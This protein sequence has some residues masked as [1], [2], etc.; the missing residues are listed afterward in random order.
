[1]S[2]AAAQCWNEPKRTKLGDMRVTTAAVSVSSRCTGNSEPTIASARVVGMPRAAIASEHRNSRI[3]ERS[4]AR[5]SPI[6]EY[7]V[8]PAPFNCSSHGPAS[9]RTSPSRW[10]RPSPSRP[11][12]TPNWWP[13]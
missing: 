3:D 9:P 8:R 7:G 2:S 5:P 12:Q 1:M 6:R 4:T 13:E 10:A 11:A